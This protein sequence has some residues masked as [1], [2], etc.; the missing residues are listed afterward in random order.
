VEQARVATARRWLSLLE[1]QRRQQ[2]T[3]AGYWTLDAATT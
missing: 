2:R 3:R 1:R